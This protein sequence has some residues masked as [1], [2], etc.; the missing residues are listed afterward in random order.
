MA[1]VMRAA[2]C[3]EDSH[4]INMEETLQRLIT[5]NKVNFKIFSPK[6][7]P[8]KRGRQKINSYKT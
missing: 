8:P 5:E 3:C 6:N 1:A 4:I 7:P 2:S